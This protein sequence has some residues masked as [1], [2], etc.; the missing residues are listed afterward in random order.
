MKHK[1]E[2]RFS[3]ARGEA[4]MEFAAI[5]EQLGVSTER[6]W[7]LYKSAIRKLRARP[8]TIQRLADLAFA[9]RQEREH[10]LGG[11]DNRDPMAA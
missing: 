5:A 7:Q 3:V 4:A 10:R 11:N 1:T 8:Q 2:P 6:V 9:A